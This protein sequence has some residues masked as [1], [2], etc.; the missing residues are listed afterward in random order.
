MLSIPPAT[1][2]S[3]SPVSIDCTPSIIAFIPELQTL[4]T[5]VHGVQ[6]GNSARRAACLAGACPRSAERTFPIKTSSTSLP[7]IPALSTELLIAMAPKEVALKED[8]EPPKLPIGVRAAE[9]I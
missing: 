1:T 3:L 6:S 8:N 9:T 2:I 4:F 7:S 5:V